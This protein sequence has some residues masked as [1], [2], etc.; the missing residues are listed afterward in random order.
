MQAATAA[1][2]TSSDVA[3][4]TTTFTAT[5]GVNRAQS[6]VHLSAVCINDASNTCPAAALALDL[7]PVMM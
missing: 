7:T 4:I 1:Q 2:L 3:G 6:E 5:F